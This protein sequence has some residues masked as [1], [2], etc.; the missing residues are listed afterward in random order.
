MDRLQ[1]GR[2]IGRKRRTFPTVVSLACAATLVGVATADA[3]PSLRASPSATSSVAA[4][5]SEVG[6]LFDDFHYTGSDDSKLAAQGWTV[7]SGAYGPGVPN[8]WSADGVS[9]QADPSAQGGRAMRLRA[10]TDGTAAGTTQAQISTSR[11]KF[12]SGTYAARVYFE[13]RPSTGIAGGEHPV[14]TFYAISPDRASSKENSLYSEM[15][16]EY[17]PNG[18]WKIPN[19]SDATGPAHFTTSWYRVAPESGAYPDDMDSRGEKRSLKGWHTLAMTVVDGK[20]EYYVDGNKF[21]TAAAKYNPREPMT[22]NFNIWFMNDLPGVG[23]SRSWDQ[24]VNWVYY[25]SAAQTPE[26]INAAVD[27]YYAAGTHFVDTVRKPQPAAHDT[28]GDG[29]SDVSL[30]YNYA[31]TNPGGC[32]QAAHPRRSGLFDLTGK[33]D[34]SGD[35]NRQALRAQACQEVVPKFAASGDFNGDGRSDTALFY[36][37]STNKPE[38]SA[39]NH[40]RIDIRLADPTGAGGPLSAPRTLWELDCWGP[41]TTFMTAGDFNG[42]GK[43]EPA[44]LYEYG[45]GH[46]RLFTVTP[47]GPDGVTSQWDDMNW[48]TGTKLMTSGDFNG[49]GKTDIALFKDDGTTDCSPPAGNKPLHQTVNTFTANASGD[50]GFNSG[51]GPAVA[52]GSPCWGNNTRF[53]TAGDFD[54]DGRSDLALLYDYGDKDVRPFTLTASANGDGRF[55]W[56]VSQWDGVKLTHKVTFMTAGD[57]NG[58]G[59]SDLALFNDFG[60]TPPSDPECGRYAHQSVSTLFADP[61]ETTGALQG[62]RTTWKDTC[63]GP[64]TAFMN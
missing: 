59:R 32:T 63:W 17:L 20:S 23:Q 2:R 22:L 43:S 31:A 36:N 33:A 21:F 37:Y 12:F 5:S 28:N 34:Q 61:Y 64:D 35:L 56:P 30:V 26:A 51:N 27:G 4:T 46:A 55:G 11:R 13:D 52:W 58:D 53:M 6:T 29:I 24:K 19:S 7:R 42:D 47:G 50:G 60:E 8:T 57:Y 25:N 1:P 44:L 18:G 45:G 41:N 15:D 9:F 48:G 38:C 49:D 14:E 3:S 39:V 54:L 10:T 40:V 16:H 62:P